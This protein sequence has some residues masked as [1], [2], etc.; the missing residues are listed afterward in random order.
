MALDMSMSHIL[1]ER[2]ILCSYIPSLIC[3]NMDLSIR[4]TPQQLHPMSLA[5]LDLT[6]DWHWQENARYNKQETE[7]SSLTSK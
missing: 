3:G 4:I 1:Y 2:L 7:C 6:Y 5:H